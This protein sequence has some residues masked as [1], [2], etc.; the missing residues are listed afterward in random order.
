MLYL[1]LYIRYNMTIIKHYINN[2]FKWDFDGSHTGY[3]VVSHI[4]D[5][6]K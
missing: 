1:N 5:K 4:T 3:E 6:Y 2:R